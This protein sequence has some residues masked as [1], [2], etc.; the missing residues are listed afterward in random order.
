MIQHSHH[1]GWRKRVYGCRQ[2]P[3]PQLAWKFMQ[4]E[5][6]ERQIESLFKFEGFKLLLLE[7]RAWSLFPGSREHTFRSINGRDLSASG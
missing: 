3:S 1:P 7:S 6:E 2:R 4:D 5:G